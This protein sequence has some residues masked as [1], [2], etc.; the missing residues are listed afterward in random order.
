MLLVLRK[1]P[2]P[3]NPALEDNPPT[4]QVVVFFLSFFLFLFF[5]FFILLLPFLIELMVVAVFDS[6]HQRE[7]VPLMQ[8]LSFW[9]CVVRFLI[10]DVY[11]LSVLMMCSPISSN[12]VYRNFSGKTKER[13]QSVTKLLHECRPT[14]GRPTDLKVHQGFYI[15]HLIST[16]LQ[17][18]ESHFQKYSSKSDL[19][20]PQIE[21]TSKILQSDLLTY[22]EKD[23]KTKIP[24]VLTLSPHLRHVRSIF[25]CHM[26]ILH[27]SPKLSQIFPEAP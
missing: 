1:K 24:L 26:H 2:W 21:R 19:I 11:C 8:Q 6:V 16:Q 20:K 25:L 10:L 3:T 4:E 9:P 5:S 13:I 12:K 17:N 23:R 22:K 14:V 7:Q 18:L 27:E 15:L